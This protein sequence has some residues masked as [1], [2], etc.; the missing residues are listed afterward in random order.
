MTAWRDDAHNIKAL[1]FDSQIDSE[2]SSHISYSKDLRNQILMFL[3]FAGTFPYKKIN[4]HFN[5]WNNYFCKWKPGLIFQYRWVFN[6]FKEAK[7]RNWSVNYYTQWRQIHKFFALHSCR[8]L[9]WISMFNTTNAFSTELL[10][11]I[12]LIKY[13]KVKSLRKRKYWGILKDVITY[14]SSMRSSRDI[15]E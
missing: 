14:I 5:L 9:Y 2:I 4:R 6:A 15:A 11:N 10:W 1:N 8:P 13:Q 7:C 12:Y 3:T